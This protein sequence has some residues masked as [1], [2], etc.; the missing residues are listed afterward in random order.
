MRGACSEGR[1]RASDLFRYSHINH[2]RLRSSNRLEVSFDHSAQLVVWKGSSF[3]EAGKSG[4]STY[5][6]I[7]RRR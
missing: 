2:P 6:L 1:Q 3:A 7:N 4:K 5:Q